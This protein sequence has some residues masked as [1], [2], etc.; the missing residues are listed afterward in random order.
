MCTHRHTGRRCDMNIPSQT[1]HTDTPDG[2]SSAP[3]AGYRSPALPLPAGLWT[4]RY[5]CGHFPIHIV[6]YLAV[7][8][9]AGCIGY[10]QAPSAGGGGGWGGSCRGNGPGAARVLLIKGRTC[11]CSNTYAYTGAQAY[12]PKCIHVHPNASMCTQIHTSAPICVCAYRCI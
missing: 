4:G 11:V 2:A 5:K 6:T 1:Q 10:R 8:I 3:P 9:T 12:A 7:Y